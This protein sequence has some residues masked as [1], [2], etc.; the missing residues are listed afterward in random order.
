VLPQNNPKGCVKGH[1]AE[2]SFTWSHEILSPEHWRGE[3]RWLVK[4]NEKLKWRSEEMSK[5]IV[6]TDAEKGKKLTFDDVKM[7]QLFVHRKCLY[8]KVYE[9]DEDSVFNALQL[10]DEDGKLEVGEQTFGDDTIVDKILT[11]VKGLKVEE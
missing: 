8:I 9:F 7:S 4:G 6:I 1:P 5:L 3:H 10:T 2:E 11:E